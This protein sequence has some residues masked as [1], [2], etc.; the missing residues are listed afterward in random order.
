MKKKIVA[1]LLS[2]T[3]IAAALGVGLYFGT[4]NQGTKETPATPVPVDSN[5]PIAMDGDIAPVVIDDDKNEL[6][7]KA[8]SSIDAARDEI[9]ETAAKIKAEAEAEA[10]A[11]AEEEARLQAI[12]E[13]KKKTEEAAET[14]AESES[15]AESAPVDGDIIEGLDDDDYSDYDESDYVEAT[16][17]PGAPKIDIGSLGDDLITGPMDF[18]DPSQHTNQGLGNYTPST[19]MSGWDIT[20]H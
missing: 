19:D 16:P 17:A 20:I 6:D 5:S 12:E 13:A 1:T 4:L 7:G 14:V 8:L 15:P 2:L 10:E 11:K 3:V 9:S 18:G